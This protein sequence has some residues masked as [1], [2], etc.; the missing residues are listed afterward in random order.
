MMGLT[1]VGRGKGTIYWHGEKVRPSRLLGNIGVV[2]QDPLNYFI[3]PTVLDELVL[4]R[5]TKTPNDVR[6]VLS[7]MGL[8]E[9]SLMAHPKSLSG[10]QARRLAL[11]C[12][13][14]REPLPSLFVLDEPLA[15]VDWTARKDLAELFGTLKAQFAIII[16]S[17]EPGDLL[18]HADRV[19]EVRE[20]GMQE[21]DPNI[22]KRAILV[23]KQRQVELREKAK[24]EE[25]LYRSNKVIMKG[26][27]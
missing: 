20:G 11:A 21:I 26:F 15:G 23:R 2:L 5:P 10:G 3:C 18:D 14:M 12:Q 4:G 19:V 9:I 7:A 6:R 8:N 1:K 17:H 22:V 24:K 13:L 27:P 25:M 16:V